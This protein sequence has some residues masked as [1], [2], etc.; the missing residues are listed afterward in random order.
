MSGLSHFRNFSP[1]TTTL[2]IT[3][4]DRELAALFTPPKAMV[5]TP[6]MYYQSGVRGEGYPGMIVENNF[7]TGPDGIEQVINRSVKLV[8]ANGSL[9][10]ACPHV[11]DPKLQW[12]YAIRSNGAWEI[13]PY[14]VA[15]DAEFQ[16]QLAN[17]Q[18][19]IAEMGTLYQKTQESLA[20]LQKLL[21]EKAPT[22][23]NQTTKQTQ[24]ANDEQ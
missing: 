1:R 12:N 16:S 2:P 24:K 21:A 17:G 18:K 9:V 7:Q 8:L 19:L 22:G 13:A 23:T 15:K 6:I 5:G 14:V 10:R 20:A 3:Q 11:D 4:Q